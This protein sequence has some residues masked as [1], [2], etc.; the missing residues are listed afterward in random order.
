MIFKLVL[1]GGGE[2]FTLETSDNPE[3]LA[4]LFPSEY[5]E[6]HKSIFSRLEAKSLDPHHSAK[7]WAVVR[8]WD[9]RKPQGYY[10]KQETAAPVKAGQR[11]DSLS[12]LA[13][14]AG[15]KV[16]SMQ[17]VYS[18]ARADGRKFAAHRCVVFCQVADFEEVCAKLKEQVILES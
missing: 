16:S 6:K 2:S 10:R 4:A 9:W 3:V 13:R 8:T 1:T 5:R 15:G 12:Q 7:Q 11:F 17:A 18:K 14:S